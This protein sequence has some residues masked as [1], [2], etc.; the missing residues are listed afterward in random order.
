MQAPYT[1]SRFTMLA[2]RESKRGKDLTRLVPEV[3]S[4]V[5]ALK[6]RRER[7]LRDVRALEV[8]DPSRLDLLEVYRTDRYELRQARDSALQEA[9]Q[10]A[11]DHF[12][13]ALTNGEFK[14]RLSHGKIVH[15]DRQTYAV[16]E[17]LA[18]QF[19]MKQAAAV[20]RN[21][22]QVSAAGRNSIVRAL[23]HSLDRRHKHAI[24]RLDIKSFYDSIPHARLLSRL[25]LISEFDTVTETLV[26]QLLKEYSYIKGSEVG[27]PQG[28]ALSAQLA[29]FYLAA[30]DQVIR[31]QPGVLFYARYVDDIIIVLEGENSLRNLQQEITKQLE[32][33]G[34]EPRDDKTCEIIT[35]SKGMYPNGESVEYLGYKFSK[36]S[37]R[38]KTNLTDKRS[39]RRLARMRQCFALWLSSS[40]DASEPNTGHDGL[41][42]DRV[43][44][45]AG[46]TRLLNS[47]D[48]VAIGLYFSN[49]ALDPDAEELEDLDHELAAFI[50]KNRQK[51]DSVLLTKLE[52]ISFRKMFKTR[53]FYRFNQRRVRLISQAWQEDQ[54]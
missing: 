24:Y 6:S 31:V 38:L 43:R 9:L 34:L 37:G 13:T 36:R 30:F 4:T 10:D 46:N 53:P 25:R 44:Y 19:P 35:C 52:S 8:D 40:P 49:S 47:K 41:L 18:V 7:Y 1:L 45:L 28:V 11:L 2:E 12:E 16:S 17:N 26:R 29:E 3:A 48:N 14:W 23:Q 21:A 27:V 32:S 50:D 42:V 20:I 22:T 15:G 51:M 54:A 33:L 5:A 39:D